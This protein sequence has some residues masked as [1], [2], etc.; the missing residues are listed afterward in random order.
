MKKYILPIIFLAAFALA[1][2]AYIMKINQADGSVVKLRVQYV[3]EITFKAD[4]KDTT[5]IGAKSSSSVAKSDANSSSSAKVGAKSSSSVAKSDAKSSSSSAKAGAKSSSSVAKSDAKS[6]SSAKAGAKS[7]SSKGKSNSS[8]SAKSD[9]IAS[10]AGTPSFSMNFIA[11]E[12]LFVLTTAK[13]NAQFVLYDLSGHEV[14]NIKNLD[15]GTTLVNLWEYKLT[16]GRYVAVLRQG[17]TLFT[18][19]INL[20]K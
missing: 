19:Q 14:V 15:A 6:S 17:S 8:S 4:A 13:S 11:S 16:R 12:K 5:L 10:L 1:K 2:P 9:A 7:S 3:S 18:K 20:A